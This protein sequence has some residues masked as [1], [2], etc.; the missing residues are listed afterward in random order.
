MQIRMCAALWFVCVLI[1]NGALLGPSSAVRSVD[2]EYVYLPLVQRTI[3]PTIDHDHDHGDE[4]RH[5]TDS[6]RACA[7]AHKESAPHSAS[8]T[9][10]LLLGEPLSFAPLVNVCMYLWHMNARA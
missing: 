10:R 7:C 6:E 2:T 8:T 9:P 3:T 4:E 5:E 1:L